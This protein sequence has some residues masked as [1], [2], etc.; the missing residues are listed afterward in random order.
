MNA[1]RQEVEAIKAEAERYIRLRVGNL[2]HNF[3]EAVHLFQGALPYE[4]MGAIIQEK[5][6]IP[7]LIFN[8]INTP[9]AR[10]IAALLSIYTAANEY[11]LGADNGQEE[12]YAK[13]QENISK[14]T[15]D[16]CQPPDKYNNPAGY[17]KIIAIIY[18]LGKTPQP[19]INSILL[20]AYQDDA[21]EKLFQITKASYGDLMR[22]DAPTQEL[23]T[24]LPLFAQN[25]IEM[26]KQL[27]KTEALKTHQHGLNRKGDPKHHVSTFKIDRTVDTIKANKV[28]LTQMVQAITKN[29]FD[30]MSEKE[31]IENII[32][33]LIAILGVK[34]A[35][36]LL[37]ADPHP[38]AKLFFTL[39]LL[40]RHFQETQNPDRATVN[41]LVNT[42]AADNS[43]DLSKLYAIFEKQ[44]S[45][46]HRDAMAFALLKST[47][48]LDWLLK[49]EQEEKYA[50]VIQQ[51]NPKKYND[52]ELRELFQHWKKEQFEEAL[53]KNPESQPL[54]YG[55]LLRFNLT[56]ESYTK[57]DIS[58]LPAEKIRLLDKEKRIAYLRNLKD[59]KSLGESEDI[60]QARLKE[61]T[62]DF[63][64]ADV[65][66]LKD[67]PMGLIAVFHKHPAL[68]VT[69]MKKHGAEPLN[70][71]RIINELQSSRG[72]LVI[73]KTDLAAYLKE[74]GQADVSARTL[75]DAI[76]KFQEAKDNT[77]EKRAY[78][79][80]LENFPAFLEHTSK[81]E[82]ADRAALLEISQL[83]NIHYRAAHPQI[84]YS[85]Y[86]LVEKLAPRCSE[87]GVNS[88]EINL[89]LGGMCSQDKILLKGYLIKENAAEKILHSVI[90]TQTVEQKLDSLEKLITIMENPSQPV[91]HAGR[92]EARA[93]DPDS[94]KLNNLIQHL[95]DSLLL[96]HSMENIKRLIHITELGFFINLLENH[97]NPEIKKSSSLSLLKNHIETSQKP[98]LKLIKQL[99]NIYV[100]SSPIVD[101]KDF[102]DLYAI[103]AE[104]DNIFPEQKGSQEHLEKEEF[105]LFLTAAFIKNISIMRCLLN[106]NHVNEYNRILD[107]INNNFIKHPKEYDVKTLFVSWTKEDFEKALAINHP[108]PS[109]LFI[110]YGMLLND[111][112]V[113]ALPDIELK[114]YVKELDIIALA[115]DEIKLLDKRVRIAYLNHLDSWEKLGENENILRT[116]IDSLVHDFN[117]ADVEELKD[118]EYGLIA[119][120]KKHPNTVTELIIKNHKQA[121]G[122][123]LLETLDTGFLRETLEKQLHHDLESEWQAKWIFNLRHQLVKENFYLAGDDDAYPFTKNRLVERDLEINPKKFA[124]YAERKAREF[125]LTNYPDI[126]NLIATKKSNKPPHKNCL[127]IYLEK[128]GEQGVSA[129][130]LLAAIKQSQASQEGN[131]EQAPSNALLNAFP[132]FLEHTNKFEPEDTKA[133]FELYQL[134]RINNPIKDMDTP[135]ETYENDPIIKALTSRLNIEAEKEVNTKRREFL[136]MISFQDPKLFAGY[137]AR[138]KDK[139]PR[140]SLVVTYLR[141]FFYGATVGFIV[142]VAAYFVSKVG[143]FFN[144]QVRI[145]RGEQSATSKILD[146]VKILAGGATTVAVGLG[147]GSAIAAF[148]VLA[149]VGSVTAGLVA[150]IGRAGLSTA[151]GFFS[152]R[153]AGTKKFFGYDTTPESAADH[154]FINGFLRSI[155]SEQDI[156]NFKNMILDPA[157]EDIKINFAKT[158]GHA[159]DNS[160]AID[161]ND[162]L[163]NRDVLKLALGIQKAYQFNART[164]S[165]KIVNAIGD[166][167]KTILSI[168]FSPLL[169]FGF[170]NDWCKPAW[171][172]RLVH[173]QV[174]KALL[175]ELQA[176]KDNQPSIVELDGKEEEHPE[177]QRRSS[178]AKKAASSEAPRSRRSSIASIGMQIPLDSQHQ[179]KPEQ[180]F[181]TSKH[182]PAQPPYNQMGKKRTGTHTAPGS[183]PKS[184]LMSKKPNS[185]I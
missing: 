57:L 138:N 44:L 16:L 67:S 63:D 6:E 2:D 161:V 40:D 104:I 33:P 105:S 42:Y 182:V 89:L 127:V 7:G 1:R 123:Q 59:W 17:V 166:I 118:S 113:K 82:A 106:G 90:D 23:I 72:F 77:D 62:S 185:K 66:E 32:K 84:G 125:V 158:L 152:N 74:L 56:D 176:P 172:T 91:M 135:E 162:R 5:I 39:Y 173:K 69:L 37:D 50:K 101:I 38:K 170:R 31:S 92:I 26:V 114:K 178:T 124:R 108:H 18:Q 109:H 137:I 119:S 55:M 93:P 29:L 180:Q 53:Q 97:P 14:A 87:E 183:S 80:L 30:Q 96:D 95:T 28:K 184:E 167:P 71:P 129:N 139:K 149:I 60:V 22:E 181:D 51:I 150:V 65:R 49:G 85:Y 159:A 117:E 64:E 3:T 130:I 24:S 13:L 52:E 111:E 146:I 165:E 81:F 115:D 19:R 21:V 143:G 103:F 68:V 112:V 153:W 99:I 177:L 160:F 133:L 27:E 34:A 107:T 41:G 163:I 136:G 12:K 144:V 83:Y 47:N 75:L 88:L 116:R 175:R 156:E 126:I 94:D 9:D 25:L 171:L 131:P 73:G 154:D 78:N 102:N 169:L 145:L 142:G 48:T 134:Y 20:D 140:E 147:L 128:A 174:E 76:K 151:G 15:D 164:T 155:Q 98:D 4:K 179:K 110:R 43:E 45:E 157:N 122:R 58:Y 36:G 132:V 168:I 121:I 70:H 11:L 54:L 8:E 35:S 86:P 120:F 10:K 61:L 100:G 46:K 79:A 141:T 148:A